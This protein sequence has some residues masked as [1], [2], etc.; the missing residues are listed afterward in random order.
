MPPLNVNFLAFKAQKYIRRYFKLALI[1]NLSISFRK[2]QFKHAV[3][4]N[5][6]DEL[7][8]LTNYK[9]QLNH[10][11]TIFEVKNAILNTK[12]GVIWFKNKIVEESS[13]WQISDLIIWEPKPILKKK[14]AGNFNNLPDNGF[15]HFLIEDLPRFLDTTNLSTSLTTIYGSKSSYIQDAFKILKNTNTAYFDYPVSCEKLVVSEK[16][17]GGIFTQFDHKKLL[18][19]SKN[20][21]PKSTNKK[22]FISRK[23]HLKDTESR[24]IKYINEIELLFARNSFEIVFFEDLSLKD[25]IS[26]VKNAQVIAGFHGAGLANIVWSKNKYKVVEI[27]ES[28]VTSH[29]EH[30]AGVCKHEYRFVKASELVNF[31]KKDFYSLT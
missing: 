7:L 28:R 22:I 18:D 5:T 19:F 30:L 3:I 26:T 15:Y 12:T 13:V 27:S 29:F 23:N 31:S 10:Y 2:S 6:S 8:E 1:N 14:L 21:K 4:H 25:Q 17:P 9:S 16:T 11:R 20:I 24:G